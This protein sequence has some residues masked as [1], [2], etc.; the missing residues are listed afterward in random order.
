MTTYANN[1]VIQ[2][3]GMNLTIKDLRLLGMMNFPLADKVIFCIDM[4]ERK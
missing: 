2:V 3:E 4:D 1:L